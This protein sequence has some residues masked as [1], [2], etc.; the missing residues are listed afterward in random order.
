MPSWSAS[1]NAEVRGRGS[2]L[3]PGR[4][5]GEDEHEAPDLEPFGPDR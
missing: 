4:V 2:E 5:V 1:A 3:E